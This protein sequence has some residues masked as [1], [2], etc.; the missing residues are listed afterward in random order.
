MKNVFFEANKKMVQDEI[1][2][3]TKVD[4]DN[5]DKLPTGQKLAR[6]GFKEI[7]YNQ[8]EDRL[9]I[10]KLNK[11]EKNKV[12]SKIKEE[13]PIAIIDDEEDNRFQV[14]YYKSELHRLL[15][16]TGLYNAVAVHVDNQVVVKLDKLDFYMKDTIPDRCLKSVEKA[17]SLGLTNFVVAYPAIEDMT[18]KD[19]IILSRID[20]NTFVEIDM[21]E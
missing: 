6:S 9:L 11:I 18:L 5:F 8:L 3:M 12:I 4:N 7:T 1:E 2:E 21:W 19:P 10:K 13:N 15:S 14:F 16:I 17:K 20:R